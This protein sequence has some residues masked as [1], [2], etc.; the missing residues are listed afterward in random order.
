MLGQRR[1]QYGLHAHAVCDAIGAVEV[2]SAS[3]ERRLNVARFVWR[4][5][6]SQLPRGHLAA[7]LV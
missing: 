4:S 5:V 6:C 3:T 1:R 7:E 2:E